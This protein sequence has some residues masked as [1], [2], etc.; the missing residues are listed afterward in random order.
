[1]EHQLGDEAHDDSTGR[2]QKRHI[3]MLVSR[4]QS[5]TRVHWRI[6]LSVNEKQG[7]QPAA[8]RRTLP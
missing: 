5:R 6:H 3:S 7:W 8:G 2:R 4:L 1:M